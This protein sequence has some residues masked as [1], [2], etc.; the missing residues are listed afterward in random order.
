MPGTP[1]VRTLVVLLSLGWAA[2][3]A[4]QPPAGAPDGTRP[5][6]IRPDR[7]DST[8]AALREMPRLAPREER[9][10]GPHAPHPIK[11]GRRASDTHLP[12]AALQETLPA[13]GAIAPLSSFEGI[14]NIDGVLPPD[15]IGDVGPSHYVQWVNL[16]FAIYSKTGAL[17]YGPA[18]GASL[19]TGFGGVCG[20]NNDGD[21]VVL[22]DERADRWL[23]S[24]FALPNY[25]SGPFYQCIAVSRTGDPTG[26]WNRYQYSFSKLND[27]PKF[28]VWSDGY[29]MSMNQFACGPSGC[30]WG[31]QGVIAFDRSA[32]L[33][34]TAASGIYFD[35]VGDTSL[36][37][38]LPADADGPAAPPA[39]AGAPF[40]QMDDNPD[41]L[42]LWEFKANWTSPASSTF[43]RRAL[44]PT[45]SFDGNLCAGSRN[46]IPQPGTSRRVDPIADRL[47]YRLQYRNFGTYQAMVVNHTVDVDGNDRAGVRWYEIRNPH[48]TPVIFQQGTFAPADTVNR[49]MASAAMDAAGNIAI[50]YS[51]S[52]GTVFPSIRFTGRLAGDPPGT[53]TVAESDLRIGTGS[54]TDTSG[55][56][57]DYSMLTVDP[58]DGCTFWYT[59][60]FY[61]SLAGADWKTNIGSFRLPGCGGSTSDG[62]K[63]PSDLTAT[64]DAER[65]RIVLRWKDNASDETG[66]EVERCQG[67][68]C[69][70]FALV[71]TRA[72]G[73]KNWT[74]SSLAFST[75][76]AYRV[77]AV[78]GGTPSA[79]SNVASATTV[80]PAPAATLRIVSL[81]PASEAAGSGKWRGYVTALAQ[82]SAGAP[83]SGAKVAFALSGGTTGTAACTT[84]T[85]GRCTVHTARLSTTIASVTCTVTGVTRTSLTYDPAHSQTAVTVTKP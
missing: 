40:V 1:S 70:T 21:P 64:A 17:L 43:T 66:Y 39:G 29:Y 85:D 7:A 6:V 33:A 8:P 78:R 83:A 19:W 56:W 36:G 16:T 14:G 28:G 30:S 55:R 73:S 63:A 57:G 2:A 11:G 27:Y 75:T 74:D 5:V 13:L 60:E 22:Y 12:D 61:A 4:A 26:A 35:M 42:Q 34:G 31:G 59:T 77:R 80:T 20:N 54:Q 81:T 3:A 53:M 62:P 44:L 58:V 9:E 50:G 71:K 41:R 46:C 65:A 49:W 67:A 84:G 10:E 52:S 18:D 32:M 51:V 79:Y 45:A 37:G 23:M 82:T 47:M 38:M 76:Y 48:G 68:G 72:A 15:T 24:Q 69:A 25:P